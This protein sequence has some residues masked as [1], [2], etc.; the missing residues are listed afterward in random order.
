MYIVVLGIEFGMNFMQNKGSS[1]MHSYCKH[2]RKCIRLC[3]NVR[4]IMCKL[5]E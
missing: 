3:L 4:C 2:V 1:I 5:N